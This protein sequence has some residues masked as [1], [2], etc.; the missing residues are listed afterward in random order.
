[1]KQIEKIANYLNKLENVYTQIKEWCNEENF[2]IITEEIEIEEFLK[3]KYKAPKLTIPYIFNDKE[4]KIEII[5]KGF[6]LAT[7]NGLFT[8]Q[9]W[10]VS[11][12]ILHLIKEKNEYYDKNENGK[13][14]K[15]CF[16]EN[17]TKDGWYY[18]DIKGDDVIAHPFDKKLFWNLV[19]LVTDDEINL[20]KNSKTKKEENVR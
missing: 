3:K 18:L 20:R 17:V 11:E 15:N 9:G 7:A 10:I 13:K 6:N 4:R 12:E 19:A 16:F 8:I 1:M 5:P 2:S 14:I